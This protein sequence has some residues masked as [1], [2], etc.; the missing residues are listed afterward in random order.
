M[1]TQQFLLGLTEVDDRYILEANVFAKR[2][3]TRTRGIRTAFRVLGGVFGAFV[4][5]AVMGFILWVQQREAI[6]PAAESQLHLMTPE[7]A[8]EWDPLGSVS[9]DA[10]GVEHF[11]TAR[12][13]SVYH[14][15]CDTPV[16]TGEA[17]AAFA[18]D[19]ACTR[20]VTVLAIVGNESTITR[21]DQ[22]KQ[23][24]SVYWV[25]YGFF[26]E[27][28][29]KTVKALWVYNDLIGAVTYCPLDAIATIGYEIMESP[30][31]EYDVSWRPDTAGDY[32]YKK[33]ILDFLELS[34]KL[35]RYAVLS[36]TLKIQEDWSKLGKRQAEALMNSYAA[37]NGLTGYQ[38]E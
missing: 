37:Q 17:A 30:D 11:S 9:I 29:Q 25:R 19:P 16:L 21:R 24:L 5:L 18:G 6:L 2:S 14:S 20:V 36:Q 13:Q 1:T 27:A 3:S 28:G 26:D 32:A 12:N 10:G 23:L 38:W 33:S 7:E 31:T 22:Y 34:D 35:E 15:L 8:E 4:F